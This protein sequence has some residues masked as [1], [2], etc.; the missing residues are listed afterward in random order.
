M[1]TSACPCS[2]TP[3]SSIIFLL[4]YVAQG[5]KA[6]PAVFSMIALTDRQTEAPF[7]E[8]DQPFISVGEGNPAAPGPQPCC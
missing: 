8:L 4:V 7:V 5:H 3:V 2:V 1:N 6:G